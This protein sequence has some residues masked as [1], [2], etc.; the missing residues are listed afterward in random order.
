[1][2]TKDCSMCT[3]IEKTAPGYDFRGPF[4]LKNIQ[5][6]ELELIQIDNKVIIR[7]RQIGI[8]AI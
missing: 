2:C 8:K 4:L 1:M 7:W 3:I 5:E 6:G